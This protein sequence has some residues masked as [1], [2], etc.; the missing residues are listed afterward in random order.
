[1]IPD[2]DLKGNLFVNDNTT[3]IQFICSTN[4]AVWQ[5][6]AE[7]LVEDR[8]HDFIRYDDNIC[9]HKR[10][11]CSP[12]ICACS[13]DCKSFTLNITVAQEVVNHLYSCAS[14]IETGGVT[15]IA[16]ISVKL[17]DNNGF[18]LIKKIVV[19]NNGTNPPQQATTF[20]PQTSTN[21]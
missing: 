20:S 21:S 15:Y 7:F 10:W 5:C 1:L 13:D 19:P 14:R 6:T 16:N 11:I 18:Q 3:T 4:I 12:N 9:Y 17:N 8:T 2:I